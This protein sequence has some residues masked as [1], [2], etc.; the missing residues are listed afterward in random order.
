MSSVRHPCLLFFFPYNTTHTP[1]R[2]TLHQTLCRRNPSSSSTHTPN[3]ALDSGRWVL[4]LLARLRMHAHVVFDNDRL[5]RTVLVADGNKQLYIFTP[6]CTFFCGCY[7]TDQWRV[8][9]PSFFLSFFMMCVRRLFIAV[10]FL[11]PGCLAAVQVHVGCEAR[12][13]E[14]QCDSAKL[15]CHNLFMES[16]MVRECLSLGMAT[17]LIQTWQ[18]FCEVEYCVKKGRGPKATCSSGTAR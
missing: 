2:H 18:S 10:V 7:F 15:H 4:C 8:W 6:H 5:V 14:K 9:V 16:D 17:T 13:D 3:A 11:G 1:F 12:A